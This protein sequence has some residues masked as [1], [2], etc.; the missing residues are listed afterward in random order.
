MFEEGSFR[1]RPRGFRRKA[2][3]PFSGPGAPGGLYPPTVVSSAG[4][5]GLDCP[6]RHAGHYDP[7]GHHVPVSMGEYEAAAAVGLQH[8]SAAA[9]A[10]AAAGGGAAHPFMLNNNHQLLG[11]HGYNYPQVDYPLPPM[12]S[13]SA[14][15]RHDLTELGPAGPWGWGG[16]YQAAAAPPPPPFS[17]ALE[18]E[19]ALGKK[20]SVCLNV[21][22]CL[23][24]S[25]L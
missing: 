10:A 3:K 15:V 23:Y 7:M 20:P 11:Y 8:P 2:I 21:F 24:Q 16:D 19:V 18:A 25:C 22:S 17:S 9:T 12:D 5:V 14:A 6:T 4:G 1:R 13:P